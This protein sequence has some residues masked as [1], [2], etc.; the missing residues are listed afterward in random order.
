[1]EDFKKI[2]VV[3]GP[4]I[5]LLVDNPTDLKLVDKGAHGAVFRL[6]QDKCVKIYADNHNAE[7]EAKSY[8]MGQGSEIVPILYEVGDNFIIMEFIDGISLWKYLSNK[9]EISFD[10]AKKIIFLLKEMKRLGFTRVDSSLRHIIVTKD[11]SLK[12]IDLVYA[13]VRKDS[14]PVKVFTELQ[15]IGLVKPFLDY[16]KI[17]DKELFNDWNESM[18]EFM[19]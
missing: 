18:A 3:H 12:A 10:I 14:K 16:V 5:A 1:L 13:Y 2:S 6:S 11:E 8:R 15:K 17:I 7:M 9:K 4:S 19:N